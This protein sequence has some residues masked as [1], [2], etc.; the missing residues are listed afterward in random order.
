MSLNWRYILI[1]LLLLAIY[2]TALACIL[3][4]DHW[5]F[6]Q[7]L[8]WQLQFGSKRQLLTTLFR[9]ATI[10]TVL[11]LPW[12]ANILV[13]YFL[14]AKKIMSTKTTW[15]IYLLPVS[16]AM[17]VIGFKYPYLVIVMALLA[18]VFTVIAKRI[19]SL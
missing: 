2:P 18:V 12:L 15:L 1:V 6:D 8:Q 9:D 3:L 19:L 17:Y 7:Q 13:V 11:A 5:F 16:A 10:A 4:V 14:F